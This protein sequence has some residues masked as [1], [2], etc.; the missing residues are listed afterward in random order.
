[1][2]E[3]FETFIKQYD[4]D[5]FDIQRKY[6]HSYRVAQNSYTLA[7]GLGLS[8]A[9]QSLAY[10][11]GLLHDLGRFE[12]ITKYHTYNDI[13][14]IDHASYSNAL[15]FEQNMIEAFPIATKDYNVVS[16]AIENHN[17]YKIAA[18]TDDRAQLFA[19]IIRDADK[20]DILQMIRTGE[21]QIREDQAIREDFLVQ[22]EK[23]QPIQFQGAFNRT[24]HVLILLAFI[25]DFQF[26]MTDTWLE[27]SK[28]LDFLEERLTRKELQAAISLVKTYQKTKKER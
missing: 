26:P 2:N 20:R 12:Q 8:Q 28:F 11:I 27:E 17:K 15:L 3:T 4:L 18:T 9:D 23:R 19:Q 7:Q 14:S 24:E 10:W 22:F 25:F 5:D 6:H 16:F 21:I 1:M 13:V